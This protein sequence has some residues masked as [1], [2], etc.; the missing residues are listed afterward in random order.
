MEVS[1][2]DPLCCMLTTWGFGLKGSRLTVS[3]L[4][5]YSS[6]EKY[7]QSVVSVTMYRFFIC[8]HSSVTGPSLIRLTILVVLAGWDCRKCP[9]R[10]SHNVITSELNSHSTSFGACIYTSSILMSCC[11]HLCRE[12]ETKRDIERQRNFVSVRES[13]FKLLLGV[14][15]NCT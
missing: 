12:Y 8:S 4:S 15:M 1:R 10:C 2:S 13:D 3:L 11:K 9:I 14:G 7:L 5:H 6:A